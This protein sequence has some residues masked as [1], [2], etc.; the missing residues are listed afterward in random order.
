MG[1]KRL[2]WVTIVGVGSWASWRAIRHG[3]APWRRYAGI[4]GAG[5][6]LLLLADINEE[7]AGGLAALTALSVAI[8]NVGVVPE[9]AG[10]I[11]TGGNRKK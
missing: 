9:D 7:I 5:T 3:E 1:G 4:L 8:G 11:S 10:T 2:V 6:M